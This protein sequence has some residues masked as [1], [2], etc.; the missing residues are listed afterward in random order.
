[1]NFKIKNFFFLIL[2]C[3]FSVLFIWKNYAYAQNVPTVQKG[4]KLVLD[5][6]ILANFP[7]AEQ[8]ENCLKC[9]GNDYYFLEDTTNNISRKR[10]M[11]SNYI[12]DREAFFKSN[13]KSFACLDCHSDAF[14]NFPHQVEERVQ[15][16]SACLDCHGGDENFAK[17]HF[18]EIQSE[19]D[20]STHHAISGF[21]CWKCHN[22]HSYKITARNN[23][24]L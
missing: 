11:C 16:Y 22:P 9:H 14:S 2:L 7:Y 3:F 13:H 24:N 4:N 20:K 8:N 18:E 15:E 12:I 21:T 23:S 19:Y 17:Y 10:I 5:S 1:M 6:A